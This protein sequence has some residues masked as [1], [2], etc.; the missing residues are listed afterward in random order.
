MRLRR[1]G[2]EWGGPN[3]DWYWF[4][5]W[6][7]LPK[8]LRY[9]G[10]EDFYYDGPIGSFGLWFTNLSWQLPWKWAHGDY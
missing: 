10:Y 7:W 8:G 9:W 5:W 4:Y 2:V 3:D 1:D 6:N